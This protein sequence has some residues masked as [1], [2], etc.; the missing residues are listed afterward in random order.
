MKKQFVFS[1]TR[2]ALV[3]FGFAAL[4]FMNATMAFANGGKGDEPFVDVKFIGANDNKTQFQ[5]DM[6]NDNDETYLLTIQ[7]GEGMYLYKEK[8]NAKTFTKKFALDNSEGPH[9]GK[10]VF[11]HTG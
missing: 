9:T 10:L 8:I 1:S 3:R 6:I 11:T 2:N 5:V 4:L 7:D